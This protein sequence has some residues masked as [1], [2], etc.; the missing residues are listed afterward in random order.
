MNALLLEMLKTRSELNG[1]W[2]PQWDSS[3]VIYEVYVTAEGNI[4]II[5]G[6]YKAFHP[7]FFKDMESGK[8]F[9]YKHSDDLEEYDSL[10][11]GMK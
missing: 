6:A 9:I 8:K 11:W 3:D 10:L 5:E 1:N 2:T 4:S 7:F